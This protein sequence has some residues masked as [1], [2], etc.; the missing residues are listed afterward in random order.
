M[1][2]SDFLPVPA[3]ESAKRILCFQPHPDDNEV[4]AGATLAKLARGGCEV[5]FVTM[6]DGSK[7]IEDAGLSAEEIRTIRQGEAAAAGEILGVSRQIFLDFVDGETPE[8]AGMKE[9]VIRLIREVQPGFVLTVDPWLPYEA[10]PDHRNVG[11]AVAEAISA[12][13]NRHYLPEG[14][15]PWRVE[16]LVLHATLWPNTFVD[17]DGYWDQKT[18]A[19]RAHRSQFSDEEWQFLGPYFDYKARGYAEGSGCERAEAFKVLPP[20]TLHMSTDTVNF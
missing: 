14:P 6:T 15:A 13:G 2:L 1:Q 20:I 4:G 10:H 11:L 3:L 7:G 17:V 12:S 9:A 5:I 8:P 16:A 18:A 19:I